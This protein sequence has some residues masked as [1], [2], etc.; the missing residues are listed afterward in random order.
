MHNS[1]S[2]I[3]VGSLEVHSANEKFKT[4]FPWW[5]HEIQTAGGVFCW[6][7]NV[8]KIFNTIQHRCKFQ[9]RAAENPNT[10]DHQAGV[11]IQLVMKWLWIE[12]LSWHLSREWLFMDG[13]IKFPMDRNE[14]EMC[15]MGIIICLWILL[16]N[17]HIHGMIGALHA[18][19]VDYWKQFFFCFV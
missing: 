8:D 10:T 2:Q 4:L 15:W 17:T 12:L 1:S 19:Q 13:A 18:M 11:D 7:A 14:C 5:P 3:S 16:G 9:L 6:R